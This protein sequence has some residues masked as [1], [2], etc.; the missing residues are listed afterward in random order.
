VDERWSSFSGVGVET[1][2]QANHQ[3]VREYWRHLHPFYV[4]RIMKLW[5]AFMDVESQAAALPPE[6]VLTSSFIDAHAFELGGRRVELL[7]T[8]GG[9]TTDA[10]AVWM[11]EQQTVF[12]GNLMGPFFGHVPNLYTLRGDKIR[13][14]MASD[15][16]C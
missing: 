5:G 2:A 11:P 13:S 7:A 6:P 8:P 16:R 9:E 12:I 1:I 3:D 15:D 14:A 4:R 10:L